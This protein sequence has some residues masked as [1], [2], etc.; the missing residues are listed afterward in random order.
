MG[1]IE[2]ISRVRA[3]QF[4]RSC[5]EDNGERNVRKINVIILRLSRAIYCDLMVKCSGTLFKM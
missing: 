1:T 5:L 4:R 3:S 2:V